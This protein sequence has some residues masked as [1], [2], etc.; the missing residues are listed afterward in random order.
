MKYILVALSS[1]IRSDR[2]EHEY[3][4]KAKNENSILPTEQ[5]IIDCC[6]LRDEYKSFYCLYFIRAGEIGKI[7]FNSF[8]CDTFLLILYVTYHSQCVQYANK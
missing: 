2:I 8:F 4:K 7:L 6:A 5:Y 1:T 3:P